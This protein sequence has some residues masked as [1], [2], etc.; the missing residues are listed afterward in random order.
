[1]ESLSSIYAE[2]LNVMPT[3]V[4]GTIVTGELR[5]LGMNPNPVEEV[6]EL[7]LTGVNPNPVEAVGE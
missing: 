7:R 6:G 1:M 2:L 3:P 5:L 4:D